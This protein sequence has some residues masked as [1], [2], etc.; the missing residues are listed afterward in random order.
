MT[1]LSDAQRRTIDD[2]LAAR[3]LDLQTRVRE[4]KAEAAERPSSQGPQVEDM[5][6]EGEQRFRIGM[7][8]VELLREQE[9]LTEVVAARERLAQGSYGE[10]IDCGQDIAFERLSAQ[11]SAKRCLICQ[12]AFEK[13]HGTTL[14]YST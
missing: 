5:V 10:C 4:A 6:E 3:E 14:R 13:R 8:H 11:P 2:L 1:I 12:E 9:E 7:E